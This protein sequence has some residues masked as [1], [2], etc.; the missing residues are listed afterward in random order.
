MSKKDRKLTSGEIKR[1]KY[2]DEQVLK[3]EHEGYVKKDLTISPSMASFLG[4]TIMLPVIALFFG[5]FFEV[6]REKLMLQFNLE[7]S[8]FVLLS[9][10]VLTVVHEVIHGITWAIFAKEHLHSIRFGMISTMLM[11]YCTCNAALTRIQYN[12]GVLSPTIVIGFIPAITAI[13]LNNYILFLVSIIMI[14]SG[15]GDALIF[16]KLFFYN[17]KGKECIY[18]D[19]PYDCGVVVFEH[20]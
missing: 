16:W 17:E 20:S 7:Q 15:G 14:L 3:L 18:M 8:I 10:L 12:L 5:L 13:I 1:K 19:H 2:F 4:L 9:V 6:N 11:P